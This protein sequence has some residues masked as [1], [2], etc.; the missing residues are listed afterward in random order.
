MPYAIPSIV[1]ASS[2][3]ALIA[4]VMLFASTRLNKGAKTNTAWLFVA[5]GLL[6]NGL[7]G[8]VFAFGT[9]TALI[10]ENVIF[11]AMFGSPAGFLLILIGAVSL[12]GWMSRLVK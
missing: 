9:M 12:R 6:L 8:V 2:G 4:A 3:L 7:S 5:F 11:Y 10:P 1:L